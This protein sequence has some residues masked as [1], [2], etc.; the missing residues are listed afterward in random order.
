VREDDKGRKS[1]KASE[2]GTLSTEKQSV[3]LS[4]TNEVGYEVRELA[5]CQTTESFE[6]Y[7]KIFGFSPKT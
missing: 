7:L 5:G 4:N 3:R 2:A 1:P 6:G